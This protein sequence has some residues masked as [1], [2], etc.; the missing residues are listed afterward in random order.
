M[1]FHIIDGRII[2]IPNAELTPEDASRLGAII[3]SW[4]GQ[5]T[6]VVSGRDYNPS[7]RMLKRAFIS[8]LMS[9]GVDVMDFHESVAGE[10]AFSIK[11]FGARGGFIVSTYPRID[12]HIR[13][14]VF[15]NPGYEIVGNELEK[16]I[17]ETR[18]KRMNPRSTGWVTYAEYI[19]R[20]Y[21]SAL[22]S[23]IATDRIVD[24]EFSVV[25]DVSHGPSDKIIPE[26]MSNL[27]VNFVLINAM[28]LNQKHRFIY[29]LVESI[30][31]VSSIVRI[32][33]ADLGVI[34]N[35]D[36]SSLILV[37]DKGR[38]LLPEEMLLVLSTR[39]P[40]GSEIIVTDD[41]FGFVDEILKMYK[42]NVLRISGD[43]TG[44]LN[45]T[46]NR[47]PI[48]SMNGRGG[49]IHPLFSLGY[50]AILT[51]VKALEVLAYTD[52]SLSK[53]VSE[54]PYP[55]YYIIET[56]MSLNEVVS[57]ICS[58][59]DV[60]CVSYIA[61]YRVLLGDRRLVITIDPVSGVARILVDATSRDIDSVL[62][63]IHSV[64]RRGRE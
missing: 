56:N 2:G 9:V 42:I 53:T 38:V 15:N 37:D 12:D 63:I 58:M 19:H 60:K 55:K 45:E 27:N 18:I 11:R 25:I 50:D 54:Y 13:F 32:V 46:V 47:R 10:I 36:A 5:G 21:I 33:E 1:G 30:E 23:F 49:C 34:L 61:G 51:L 29:P 31:K 39:V 20:L 3:G 59:K 24:R 43:E 40:Q 41:M 4:Y 14:R 6:L 44:F 26:L 17:K 16:I 64:L 7:S 57:R 48:M 52:K 28:K 22:T 62:S 8:G 35:N